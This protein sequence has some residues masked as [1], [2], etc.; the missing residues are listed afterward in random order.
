MSTL[1]DGDAKA[2]YLAAFVANS[3]RSN[4]RPVSAGDRIES[5]C[6]EPGFSS[7]LPSWRW[8]FGKT[9]MQTFLDAMPMTKE[10]MIAA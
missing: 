7:I 10:K 9:P 8:C 2:P 1:P 6:L 5:F 4:A 3:W